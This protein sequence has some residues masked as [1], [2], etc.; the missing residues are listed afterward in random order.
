M[1][2]ELAVLAAAESSPVLVEIDVD[3]SPPLDVDPGGGAVVML[4]L[5]AILSPSRLQAASMRAASARRRIARERS[6]GRGNLHSRGEHA[7]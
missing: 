1:S 3:V 2:L 4:V 5:K 6:A 7:V